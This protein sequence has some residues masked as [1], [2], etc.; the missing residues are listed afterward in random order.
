MFAGRVHGLRNRQSSMGRWRHG[1]A[2]CSANFSRARRRESPS[3]RAGP[4]RRWPRQSR[5]DPRLRASHQ[6]WRRHRRA[7]SNLRSEWTRLRGPSPALVTEIRNLLT[8]D[9]A[10]ATAQTLRTS[11]TGVL[12]RLLRQKVDAGVLSGPR[13]SLLI[14]NALI[15][16]R[17]FPFLFLDSFCPV[18]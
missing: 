16:A 8:E 9:R 17:V 7:L 2:T 6:P 5:E 13:A 12:S 4:S 18:P 14:E 1:R 10:S 3:H 11:W 15:A